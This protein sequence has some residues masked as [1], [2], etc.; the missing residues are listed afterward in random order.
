MQVD[1]CEFPENLYYDIENDV[2]F[3]TDVG[4]NRARMGIST[5]LSF[6]AGRVLKVKLNLEL[7][8]VEVGKKVGTIESAVY[9]G[10]VRSPVVGNIA[11]M[12][13]GL[14][15]DPRPLDESPY[16][17][18]WIAEY[19]SFDNSSLAR[20]CYGEIAREKLEARIKELKVKCFKLLPDDQMYSIGTE[21]ITT[22]VNL[23]ELLS[24]R[25]LGSVV[26]LVTDDPLSDV[27][28]VRWAMRTKNEVVETRKED[29]LYHFIVK[30]TAEK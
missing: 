6:V 11:R 14:Q 8:Q 18:G 25:P 16:G 17:A 15:Q 4:G 9:F 12:N 24:K 19:D 21:C 10:A 7:K 29:N 13:L 30:K 20:L 3:Q 27:E 28:M 23:S 1:H 2:W 22:L 26:H 5:I